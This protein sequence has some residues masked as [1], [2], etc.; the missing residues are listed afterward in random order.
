VRVEAMAR[1]RGVGRC[2]GVVNKY[3][4]KNRPRNGVFS[5]F[6]LCPKL[7]WRQTGNQKK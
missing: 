6:C 7:K 2:F 4:Y 3:K 1:Q 5:V